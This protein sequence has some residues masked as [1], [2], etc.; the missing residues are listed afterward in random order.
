MKPE[1]TEKPSSL[2]TFPARERDKLVIFLTPDHGK[3]K[4]GRMARAR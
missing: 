4:G 1:R 3:R 2:N